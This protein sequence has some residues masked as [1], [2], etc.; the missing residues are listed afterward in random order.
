ME[1]VMTDEEYRRIVSRN[2]KRIAYDNHKTQADI[3]RDLNLK[4][5][6]VSSWM[7]GTRMIQMPEIDLLCHY[8]NCSRADIMEDKQPG[9]MG[10]MASME[11][12]LL[13]QIDKTA[14]ELSD[15][16]KARLLAYAQKLHE[17]QK[18]EEEIK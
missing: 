7:N 3:V 13:D 8:F 17:I 16:F 11:A 2:I 5:P 9:E 14:N 10:R 1:F 6:T 18:A 12:K 15:D 4:Q